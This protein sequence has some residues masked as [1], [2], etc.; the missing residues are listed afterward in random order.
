MMK[1][2]GYRKQLAADF[3]ASLAMLLIIF[4]ML[5]TSFQLAIYGDPDY[6]F[7][8]KEYQKYH[9]TEALSMKLED[10]MKVTHYMMDYLIGKEEELSIVTEVEGRTQDFFND[11]DRFHMGEVRR[12]FLG[13]LRLRNMCT[14]IALLLIVGLVIL[15]VDW[16]HLLPKA[17][18]R[19]LLGLLVVGALLAGAFTVDFTRCFTIFHEIFF[20]NDLWMFNPSED[21]MIRML[22]EGF[23][24]DMVR[25]IGV[26]FMAMVLALAVIFVIWRKYVSYREK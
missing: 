21:Y 23:F 3:S 6:G 4:S 16:K 26:T 18:F 15:K 20:D 5:L 24:S 22:P 9:V 25:R 11:Q 13:G 14:L 2:E 10:V 1:K 7:Y 17:Y 19:G 12:L 8:E